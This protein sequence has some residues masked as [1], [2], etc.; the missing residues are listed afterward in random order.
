MAGYAGSNRCRG[1]P[2]FG[3]KT[4]F[5]FHLKILAHIAISLYAPHFRKKQEKF[6]ILHTIAIFHTFEKSWRRHLIVSNISLI[7]TYSD[8]H[9]LNL[10]TLGYLL[11]TC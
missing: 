3:E 7:F 6:A 2:F 11:R 4:I 10:L 5:P 9:I 1:N 8:L